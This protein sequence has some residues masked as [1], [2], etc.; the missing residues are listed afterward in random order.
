MRPEPFRDQTDR[1]I[2]VMYALIDRTYAVSQVEQQS[3]WI[4]QSVRYAMPGNRQIVRAF[5][6]PVR[7]R[8]ICTIP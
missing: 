6:H 5:F 8:L 2:R 7:R 3:T 1:H 4:S